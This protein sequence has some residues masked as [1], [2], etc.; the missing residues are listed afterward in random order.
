[1]ASRRDIRPGFGIINH[2]VTGRGRGH[3]TLLDVY[4]LVLDLGDQLD[5]IERKLDGQHKQRP[6]GPAPK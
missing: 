6:A 3:P 4:R 2:A 1:M 5:R